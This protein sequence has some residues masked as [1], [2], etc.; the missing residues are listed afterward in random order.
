MS[1]A[2]LMLGESLRQF[3]DLTVVPE[4]QLTAARRRLALRADSQPDVTQLRRLANETD[5]WTAVTGNI[6]VA[7]PKLRITVQA[8]DV[9]TAR[10][11]TTAQS[12]IAADADVRQAFDSLTARLVA[13]TG[14]RG[15][16]VDLAALTTESVDAYRAYVRGIELL[17]ASAFSR[18]Q[19]EFKEA[20][21]LDS[22]FA[23][24]WA[25]LAYAQVNA[26][27]ATMVDPSSPAVHSIEQSVRLGNKL[28][29]RHLEYMRATQAF[30]RGQW[31]R[32]RKTLDSLVTT[33]RDELDAREQLAGML[34]N[35]FQTDTGS[36][37]ARMTSSMNQAMLLAREVLERDPGRRNVHSIF[38]MGYAT[39]GGWWFGERM[40]M[41]GS[42]GSLAAML[43]QLMLRGPDVES[44]PVLRDTIVLMPR[45][46]FERLSPIERAGLR[47]RSADVGMEWVARWILAGPQDAEA[48]LW[49]SRLSELRDD[50]PRALRELTIADSL[51]I[52]SAWENLP[53]R[54]LA[55]LVRDAQFVRAAT[56][57]DS[58]RA[59]GALTKAALLPGLDR[60]LGYGM[61]AHLALKQWPAAA[62]LIA[63]RPVPAGVASACLNARDDLQT[64]TG[65]GGGA[66]LRAVTDTVAK[67]LP[68]LAAMPAFAPCL[69]QLLTVVN[70]SSWGRRTFA[71]S[72]LL[73]AA[74][75]LERAGNDSLAQRAA[76][77]AAVMDTTRR[78]QLLERSWYRPLPALS[79]TSGAA[80]TDYLGGSAE[81]A[82]RKPVQ[83]SP[84]TEPFALAK[85]RYQG[86]ATS[87]G[88][89]K[90]P[91]RITK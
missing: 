10:V 63:V 16:R 27:I 4:E 81:T 47:R 58:L 19:Q 5:G 24:A 57:A 14:A 72:A 53:Q 67:Y 25:R 11:L 45:A 12:V 15:A 31:E 68:V 37:N 2:P 1:G 28:P 8:L 22:T 90:A 79:R 38:A 82:Q 91:P 69:A 48:H 66:G 49:A 42:Y 18:A 78:S 74:D 73:S 50:A 6:Y 70:D 33:D 29:P 23:L 86:R 59:S 7:G 39:A 43:M 61:A 84:E 54:R 46:E 77:W 9:Q 17:R 36:G 76:R 3:V 80:R 71:G 65:E 21:R 62:A 20:V 26:N 32:A 35:D 89:L 34:L 75:S 85:T 30:A 56:L 88:V 13:P 44:V 60:G 64:L 52:E 40:G 55:L 41:R 83:L 51:G 87:S